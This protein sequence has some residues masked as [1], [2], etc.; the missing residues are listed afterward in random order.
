[1]LRKANP[2]RPQAQHAA[3]RTSLEL[4]KRQRQGAQPEVH[5]ARALRVKAGGDEVEVADEVLP[6]DLRGQRD[7]RDQSV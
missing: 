4:G 6:L 1:V 5:C 3:A 7:V 2:V